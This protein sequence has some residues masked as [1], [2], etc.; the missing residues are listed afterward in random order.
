M[1]VNSGLVL[2]VAVREHVEEA[3][4]STGFEEQLVQDGRN[5][6]FLR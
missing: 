2:M 5:V 6:D 4:S 1:V 3:L